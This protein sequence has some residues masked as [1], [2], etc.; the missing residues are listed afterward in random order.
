M[1]PGLFLSILILALLLL[2]LGTYLLLPVLSRFTTRAYRGVSSGLLRREPFKRWVVGARPR[3]GPLVPYAPAILLL[4]AG[5]AATLLA[6]EGFGM[7][8][9][10]IDRE[11]SVVRT[12]DR[13]A[14]A[15]FGGTRSP[16]ITATLSVFTWIGNP[17]VLA[18]ITLAAAVVFMLDG[19]IRWAMYLLITISL[20]G[21]LNRG[22]KELFARARPEL[23]EA[24]MHARGFAF[25]SGHAMGAT[26]VFG[27][28]AYLAM[29]GIRSWP[30]RSMAI[31]G[32]VWMILMISLSRVYLGVHWVSDVVAGMS[33]GI[34]WLGAASTAY[35]VIRRIRRVREHLS[36]APGRER[37][38]R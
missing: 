37:L 12:I 14:Y 35:E 2:W 1:S 25:P 24:L 31:A 23:A 28:L 5:C 7:L 29:R 6:G 38:P 3:L 36:S 27:A 33:A 15:W 9:A 21:L 11:S 10:R 22:L 18:A 32:C 19:R 20:G 30:L 26:L 17:I 4:L 8:A 34:V 13:D 16:L